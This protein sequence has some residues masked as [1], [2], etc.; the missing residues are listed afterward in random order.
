MSAVRASGNYVRKE[1]VSPEEWEKISKQYDLPANAD[2][3]F[4][5]INVVPVAR[6]EMNNMKLNNQ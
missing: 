1:D 5:V 3:V 4:V 2:T 6:E